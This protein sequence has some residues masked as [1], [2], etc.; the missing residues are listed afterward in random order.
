MREL[1]SEDKLE[2]EPKFGN[3]EVVIL[4]PADERELDQ[5]EARLQISEDIK[6]EYSWTA[7][8]FMLRTRRDEHKLDNSE[9]SALY[10]IP[11]GDVADLLEMLSLAEAYLE[12]RSKPRQFR[13]IDKSEFA[14]RQLIRAR[15]KFRTQSEKQILEKLSYCL[16]DAPAGGRVYA[17]VPDLGKYLDQV[18]ETIRVELGSGAH[19][20]EKQRAAAKVLGV[21]AVKIDPVV[22]VIENEDNFPRIRQIISDVIETEKFRQRQANKETKAA[23]A[24]AKAAQLIASA[25]SSWD[26]AKSRSKKEAS[27][28]VDAIERL[29]EKLRAKIDADPSS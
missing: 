9:L 3:I 16:I 8:A 23:S 6:A 21:T 20:S 15:E 12:D 14:F 28:Q 7:K 19:V 26:K 25:I 10:Q 27:K 4:P 24:L 5:L 2:F 11:V 13:L 29:I 18:V 17:A 22:A 1:I